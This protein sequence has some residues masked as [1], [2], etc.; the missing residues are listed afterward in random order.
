VHLAA[1]VGVGTCLLLA[2]WQWDRATGGNGLSWV[3]V[4]EWPVFA[5]VVV[6]VWWDLIHHR[7]RAAPVDAPPEVLP[8]NWQATVPFD[9]LAPSRLSLDAFPRLDELES[10]I[11]AAPLMELMDSRHPTPTRPTPLAE[12]EP[13]WRVDDVDILPPQEGGAPT[14]KEIEETEKLEAY[15]RYLADLNLHGKPKRW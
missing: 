14:P 3:Y 12:R 7:H 13:V 8:P 6:Y 11:D 1:L 4:F 9:E 15:N 10:E 2:H 5:G